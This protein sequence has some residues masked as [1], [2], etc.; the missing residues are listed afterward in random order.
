[1]YFFIFLHYNEWNYSFPSPSRYSWIKDSSVKL[2]AWVITSI[3]YNHVKLQTIFQILSSNQLSTQSL[4]LR[5]LLFN[6]Y[7]A[8][9]IHLQPLRPT[10]SHKAFSR[11]SLKISLLGLWDWLTA[12][13]P[14]ESGGKH[15]QEIDDQNIEDG[16]IH[17]Q[18]KRTCGLRN[19]QH[20]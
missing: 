13:I 6:P 9:R 20:L 12:C 3:S 11:Y 19:S 10:P 1:M 17:V 5:V 2:K 7:C 16:G 18:R 15:W 4:A 14:S 8:W